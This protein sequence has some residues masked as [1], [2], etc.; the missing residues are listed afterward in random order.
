[1]MI[2]TEGGALKCRSLS[3]NIDLAPDRR[4]LKGSSECRGA[5]SGVG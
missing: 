5:G 3:S 2:E 1:M 4:A